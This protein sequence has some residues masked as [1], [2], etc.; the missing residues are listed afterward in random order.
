MTPPVTVHSDPV[1]PDGREAQASEGYAATVHQFAKPGHYL[2]RVQRIERGSPVST[3]RL[4][5]EVG[6]R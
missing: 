1:K 2:V 3:A 5:V 4:H 6:Q